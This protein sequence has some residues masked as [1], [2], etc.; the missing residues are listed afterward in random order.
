MKKIIALVS[1]DSKIKDLFLT[2]ENKID[3]LLQ[4]SAGLQL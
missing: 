4:A 3:K 2:F 1:D